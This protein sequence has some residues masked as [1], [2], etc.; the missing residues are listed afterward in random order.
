E[1]M[2]DAVVVA[3]GSYGSPALLQRSGLGPPEIL[4][5]AGVTP[6]SDLPVGQNLRDHPQCLFVARVPPAVARMIG[7]GFAVVARGD[8]YWSFPLPLDEELGLVGVAFGLGIQ[9]PR[10]TV[11]IRSPDPSVAPEI[12]HH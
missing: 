9:E 10:G 7:P 8:G 5:A 11:S 3:A 6:I 12:D 1:L 2:A 4:A